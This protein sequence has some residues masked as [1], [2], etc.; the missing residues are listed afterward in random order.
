MAGTSSRSTQRLEEERMK[1]SVVRGSGA[2]LMALALAAQVLFAQENPFQWSGRMD[3]GQTLEVRGITGSIRAEVASGSTASV[4][5]EKRGDEDDFGRVLIRMEEVR[6]GIVICALYHERNFDRDGC[7]GRSSGDD[8]NHGND[9]S[10]DVSVEYV[11]QLPAGV[12]LMGMM[13]TG[14]IEAEG[15]RSD[16]D[17]KTVTGDIT[18]STS[19]IARASTVSGDIDVSMASTDWDD[20]HFNT[21]S[22]DII[23]RLPADLD[24]EVDFNSLS[25][26]IESDFD[27]DVRERDEGRWI[28]TEMKGTIGQGGRSLSINTVSGD[29]EIR[30]IR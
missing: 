3:T 16:L 17:V 21:V 24:A 6:G 4:V 9:D 18:V 29:V 23:L 12:E 27:I 28:G 8:S 22:G 11:V 25:G 14:D 20:M 1:G 15:L 26:D 10:I 13:V 19:G 7:D 30:R 5:A 2:A